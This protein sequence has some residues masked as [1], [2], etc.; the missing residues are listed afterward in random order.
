[1]NRREKIFNKFFKSWVPGNLEQLG[2][3]QEERCVAS[4]QLAVIDARLDLY[5]RSGTP[6]YCNTCNILIRIPEGYTTTFSEGVVPM[7]L[8]GI[9][10]LK[11]G[12]M[13]GNNTLHPPYGSACHHIGRSVANVGCAAPNVFR[14]RPA[15]R[16]GDSSHEESKVKVAFKMVKTAVGRFSRISRVFATSSIILPWVARAYEQVGK[17]LYPR[18]RLDLRAALE[19]TVAIA[20]LWV[21]P[22]WLHEREVSCFGEF[23]WRWGEDLFELHNMPAPESP[24]ESLGRRALPN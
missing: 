7:D 12:P 6:Y 5:T 16:Q 13:P 18:S 4:Y 10:K 1:L 17:Y 20:S 15:W 3:T 8:S 24:R 23:S 2:S 9:T 14:N 21:W 22:S 11:L 19:S